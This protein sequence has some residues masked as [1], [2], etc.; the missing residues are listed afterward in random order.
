MPVDLATH[1]EALC[2]SK[3]FRMDGIAVQ[4]LC[5][6]HVVDG[7]LFGAPIL[8]RIVLYEG[9]AYAVGC[10]PKLGQAIELQLSGRTI[11][12]QNVRESSRVIEVKPIMER[13]HNIIERSAGRA[14]PR[15]PQA[16]QSKHRRPRL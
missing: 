16:G 4:G 5:H 8:P 1:C 2:T 14:S 6:I 9:R 10:N 3:H 13:K 12:R 15:P 7:K 11:C